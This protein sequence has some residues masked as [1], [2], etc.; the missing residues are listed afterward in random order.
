MKMRGWMFIGFSKDYPKGK[1]AARTFM[2]EECLVFRTESGQLNMVEPYCS[3]FGVNMKTGRVA[4]EYLVCPMHSRAFN[5]D[6]SCVKA[7]QR[8]IRS[9]PIA[10]N[11][12]LVFAWF[13]QPGVAPQ[14][15]APEFLTTSGHPDILWS[16]SRLLSLHHPSVPMDN[17][18]DPRHFKETHAMFG[19]VVEEGRFQPDGHRATCTMAVEMLPPLSTALRVN[20]TRTTTW[21]D[22]PLNVTQENQSGSNIYPLCNFLTIIEGRQCRLTQIGIGRRSLNPVKWF[23]D[24]I[25]YVGSRYATWEDTAVW[26]NRKVQDPDHYNHDTDRALAQFRQ[27]FDGFAYETGSA[28]AIAA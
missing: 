2:D 14:W 23:L 20:S 13:D 18:V 17:A 8:S 10:E 12:G 28:P 19:N 7:G 24:G 1:I 22:G 6:G 5:G 16:H 26:N 25:G 15:P 21:F 27:W 9:Y 11:R 4:K 3:H